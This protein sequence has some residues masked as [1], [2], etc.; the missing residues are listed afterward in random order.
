M[1]LFSPT[2][3]PNQ[4]SGIGVW[5]VVWVSH[6]CLCL[7]VMHPAGNGQGGGRRKGEAPCGTQL[8][9]LMLSEEQRRL[10]TSTD[11]RFVHKQHL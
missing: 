3:S 5:G 8:T 1:A 11:K 10:T 9:V 4:C 2:S 6:T 7:S